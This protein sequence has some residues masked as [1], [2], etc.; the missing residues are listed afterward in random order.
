MS[1]LSRER[2]GTALALGDRRNAPALLHDSMP[3]TIVQTASG[4][5][6][7]LCL[8]VRRS[9]PENAPGFASQLQRCGDQRK[10]TQY[11]DGLRN[12]SLKSQQRVPPREKQL[13][14]FPQKENA[15]SRV[16]R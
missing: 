5:T 4:I 2:T 13:G 6:K 7:T 16:C 10:K 9:F 15:P 8:Q 14:Q 3:F 1:L 11:C 12:P